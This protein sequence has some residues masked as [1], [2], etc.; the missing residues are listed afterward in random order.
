MYA[1]PTFDTNFLDT[2]TDDIVYS[3]REKSPSPKNSS[4]VIENEQ[5]D[6]L[7]T[8]DLPSSSQRSLRQSILRRQPLKEDK[9]QKADIAPSRVSRSRRQSNENSE[10]KFRKT[11]TYDDRSQKEEE[12]LLA[13][14]QPAIDSSSILIPYKKSTTMP[15][16]KG[17]LPSSPLDSF[18]LDEYLSKQYQPL[19]IPSG[20]HVQF[21][22][23][24]PDHVLVGRS[25]G[26]TR[27]YIENV[28]RQDR[29]I[30]HKES[31]ADKFDPHISNLELIKINFVLKNGW[32]VY[33][34]ASYRSLDGSIN[35]T[36]HGRKYYSKQFKSAIE[37]V[38]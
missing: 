24:Q 31:L 33:L 1:N 36:L 19:P 27:I 18:L 29:M 3:K 20:L 4:N 10:I 26:L 6:H 16:K 34:Q 35:Q 17:I 12:L 15:V 5:A 28:R 38:K 9:G 14:H 37:K 7:K 22:T 21:F 23:S 30:D 32:I 13:E 25:A 2:G 8:D 11:K